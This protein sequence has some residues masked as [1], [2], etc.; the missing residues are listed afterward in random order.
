MPSSTEV[1]LGQL[2]QVVVCQLLKE[3]LV[4]FDLVHIFSE[5]GKTVFQLHMLFVDEVGEYESGSS[6]LALNRLH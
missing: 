1:T 6:G 4:W 2:V 3:R 5:Q